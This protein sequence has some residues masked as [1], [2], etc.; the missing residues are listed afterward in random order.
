MPK[1]A[2]WLILVLL[3]TLPGATVAQVA[4]QGE[5][6]PPRE[7]YF[8][9]PM[10]LDLPIPNLAALD[11]G[12]TMQLADVS[13]FICDN[14]VSL[15]GLTIGKQ[16]RGFRKSRRMELVLDGFVRIADSFDRRVDLLARVRSGDR[17]HAK[18]PLH[19]YKTEEDRS[20]PFRMLIPVADEL[21]FVS[22]LT[23]SHP[24]VLELTLSV[25]D[26]S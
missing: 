22:A 19:D 8:Q 12:S 4:R 10:I 23:S 6:A 21:G 7:Q 3:A 18:Q 24:P 13:R 20:T 16:Y 14:H 17:E 25:R 9:S 11:E 1:P 15:I 26:D 2:R 5:P